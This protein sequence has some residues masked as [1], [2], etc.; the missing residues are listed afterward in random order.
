MKRF[1]ACGSPLVTK[2]RSFQTTGDEWPIPGS[3]TFQAKSFSVQRTGGDESAATPEPFG[4]RKR[5]H[6]WP[7]AATADARSDSNAT[8]TFFI[9]CNL[10][11]SAGDGATGERRDVSATCL[12]CAEFHVALTPRRSP[13]ELS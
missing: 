11:D 3:L 5:V 1:P 4:P 8:S 2:M 9:P 7:W 12:I 10:S 13:T 6:S